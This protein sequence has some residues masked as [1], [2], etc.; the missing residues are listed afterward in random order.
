MR[1]T[2]N[3]L[4]VPPARGVAVLVGGTETVLQCCIL[5]LCGFCAVYVILNKLH[6]KRTRLFFVHF[7][8]IKIFGL[9]NLFVSANQLLFRSSHVVTSTLSTNNE[10]GFQIIIRA[11]NSVNVSMVS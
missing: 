11:N 6:L 10:Y 4:C 9:Q 1:A 3:L 7:L 5:N 8:N 2:D